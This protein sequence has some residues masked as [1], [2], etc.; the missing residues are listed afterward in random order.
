MDLESAAYGSEVPLATGQNVDESPYATDMRDFGLVAYSTAEE[1]VEEK[2]DIGSLYGWDV[3]DEVLEVEENVSGNPYDMEQA[4]Y[5]AT[6]AEPRG[7]KSLY[8]F[9]STSLI[10]FVSRTKPRFKASLL[11]RIDFHIEQTKLGFLSLH[12]TDVRS[13]M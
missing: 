5:S 10:S 6:E 2:I 3:G 7:Q 1:S 12:V 13:A 4:A 11:T 8:G 9:R